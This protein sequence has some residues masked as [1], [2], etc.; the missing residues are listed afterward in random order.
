[1][2]VGNG[3]KSF[4]AAKKFLLDTTNE[5]WAGSNAAAKGDPKAV[6]AIQC[7]E[8]TTFSTLTDKTFT[9]S[10]NST[11]AGST[12]TSGTYPAGFILY[13]NFTAISIATGAVYC[14]SIYLQD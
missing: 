14:Y 8:E 3:N 13:G 5:D 12:Q 10:P 9:T 7:L 2:I 11:D 4:D 1:M 6:Y